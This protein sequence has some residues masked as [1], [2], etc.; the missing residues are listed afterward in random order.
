MTCG[1]SRPGSA[2]GAETSSL[3]QELGGKLERLI[4]LNQTRADFAETFDE[5]IESSNAGSR[6][7]EELFEELVKLSRNLNEEQQPECDAAGRCAWLD[8]V[9]VLQLA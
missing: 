3:G 1:V 6:N 7:I 8:T 2:F 5:L 4:R 9:M